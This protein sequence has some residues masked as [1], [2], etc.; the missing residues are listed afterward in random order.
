M[1]VLRE[2][3]NDESIREKALR[4]RCGSSRVKQESFRTPVGS[5]LK[6]KAM[7]NHKFCSRAFAVRFAPREFRQA[8]VLLTRF[9]LRAQI[10]RHHSMAFFLRCDRAGEMYN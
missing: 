4:R 7:H 8:R 10:P 3:T 1:E 5:G 2:R 6:P 9:R